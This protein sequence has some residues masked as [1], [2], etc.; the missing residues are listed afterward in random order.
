MPSLSETTETDATHTCPLCSYESEHR[1]DVYVHVQVNHRK[2]AIAEALLAG[3]DGADH[4]A[5]V[6]EE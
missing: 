2:S 1:D 5:P 3:T 4:E 6:R